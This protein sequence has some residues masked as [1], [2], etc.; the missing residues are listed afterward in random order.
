MSTSTLG[1]RQ[2][3]KVKTL[4]EDNSQTDRLNPV[5]ADIIARI[6]K[7]L[8]R[9][10]HPNTPEAEAETAVRMSSRLQQQYN[11]TQADLVAADA[12]ADGP[13]TLSGQSAVSVTNAKPGARIIIENWASTVSGAVQTFFDCKAYTTRR[14]NSIEWMFYG[15]ATNTVAAAMAFEMVHNLVQAWSSRRKGNKNSYRL[16]VARGLRDAADKEKENEVRRVR[17]QTARNLAAREADEETQRQAEVDRLSRGALSTDA[18]DATISPSPERNVTVKMEVEPEATLNFE[19]EDGFGHSSILSEA[20][21][22]A[23]EDANST[24]DSDDNSEEDSDSCGTSE[25]EGADSDSEFGDTFKLPITTFDEDEELA[26]DLGADFEDELKRHM[27]KR[28]PS[29]SPSLFP[30]AATAPDG[31]SQNS[32][33]KRSGMLW[34]DVGALVL[35]R[36]NASKIADDHLKKQN[37]TMSKGRKRTNNIRDWDAYRAGQEDSKKIDVKRRRIEG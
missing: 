26:I 32:K 18:P 14:K 19:S 20:T 1:A 35:F 25:E 8:D 22:T 33:D 10:N 23:R 3:A 37:I 15:I 11:V 13:S 16:G 9:A 24:T 36:E 21:R 30:N 34:R 31:E 27:P 17:E 6:R 7:C 12:N 29:S 28:E 2:T 4:A 5:E